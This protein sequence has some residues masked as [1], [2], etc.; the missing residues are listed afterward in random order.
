MINKNMKVGDTFE[1]GGLKF[2]VT[3]VIDGIGYESV[4][5]GSE[6]IGITPVQIEKE[7]EVVAETVVEPVAEEVKE[8]KPVEKKTAPKKTTAK[9]KTTTKKK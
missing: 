6:V 2:K 1:D 4:R 7:K 9:K 5:V 3:K 8:E